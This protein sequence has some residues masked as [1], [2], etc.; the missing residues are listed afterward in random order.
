MQVFYSVVLAAAAQVFLKLGATAHVAE[1]WVDIR[2]LTSVWVWLGIF[3]TLGSLYYWLSAL[4]HIELNVA[5]NLSGRTD[6][7]VD[8]MGYFA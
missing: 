6:V 2:Q 1:S 7:V 5:Y 4:R 8:V 3:A